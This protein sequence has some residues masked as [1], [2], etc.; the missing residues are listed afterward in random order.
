MDYDYIKEIRVPDWQ[1]HP[2]VFRTVWPILYILMFVS[3]YLFLCTNGSCSVSS[4]KRVGLLLFT[5]QLGLNLTWSPVFFYYKKIFLGFVLA[6]ILTLS[7]GLMI[8]WFCKISAV[9]GLINIPY[10]LWLC[11]A[12][13]LNYRI[14][15]LNK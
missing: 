6:L 4:G 10:F 12:S 11:F 2:A 1:P 5:L 8:V 9:A 3:L 13:I 7:V 14:W 15:L